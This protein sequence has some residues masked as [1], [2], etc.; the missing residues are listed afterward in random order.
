MQHPCKLF[1]CAEGGVTRE[2]FTAVAFLADRIHTLRETRPILT[3]ACR[4][5]LTHDFA[6]EAVSVLLRRRGRLHRLGGHRRT[7]VRPATVRTSFS[8]ARSSAC[9]PSGGGWRD[10]PQAWWA[11]SSARPS[12]SSSP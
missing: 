8:A 7:R 10:I 3:H 5:T 9:A 11:A 1:V 12:S 2:D 4:V 6:G